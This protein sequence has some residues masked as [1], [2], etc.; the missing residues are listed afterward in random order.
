M[1]DIKIPFAQPQATMRGARRY[2]GPFSVKNVLVY[3]LGGSS[4]RVSIVTATDEVL[5]LVQLP[6]SI[7]KGPNG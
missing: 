1:A 6:M 2:F 3:D 7:E 4:L 5:D